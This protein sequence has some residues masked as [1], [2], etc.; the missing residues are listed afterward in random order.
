MA[1]NSKFL[2]QEINGQK[3]IVIQ[4][5]YGTILAGQGVAEQAKETKRKVWRQL[6]SF[7]YPTQD[8][9]HDL[10]T[11]F[12]A[13]L[14][15]QLRR[16]FQQTGYAEFTSLIEIAKVG[17]VPVINLITQYAHYA[18]PLHSLVKKL[19]DTSVDR[20]ALQEE[21]NGELRFLQQN[22]NVSASLLPTDGITPYTFLFDP[23]GQQISISPTKSASTN[24]ADY[25]HK[26]S[27]TSELLSLL[28]CFVAANFAIVNLDVVKTSYPLTKLMYELS[29][30]RK[31]FS[32][33]NVRIDATDPE[34]WDYINTEADIEFG[35][36][37][38]SLGW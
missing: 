31:C 32:L 22:W 37:A 15:F 20:R 28:A 34:K 11:N 25:P 13:H 17:S 18:G 24:P 4:T 30:E 21:E 2:I 33:E 6:S 26:L 16:T 7:R 35:K 10:R 27:R 14:I 38:A 9:I 3:V 12:P 19:W 1:E 5:N 8:F 36:A 29:G 23:D